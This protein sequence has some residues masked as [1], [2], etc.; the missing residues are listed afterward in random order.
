VPVG[1]GASVGLVGA[2]GLGEALAVDG[3]SV[4]VADAFGVVDA[5]LAEGDGFVV[6]TAMC[7]AKV[8]ISALDCASVSWLCRLGASATASVVLLTWA[9]VSGIGMAPT[10]T[11]TATATRP[12]ANTAAVM[13]RKDAG[14]RAPRSPARTRS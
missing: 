7:G 11:A 5:F 2:V 9:V 10:P 13:T 3:L 4:G 12:T 1:L 6:P 8:A 14:G